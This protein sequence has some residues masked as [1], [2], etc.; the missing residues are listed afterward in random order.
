MRL[1][2]RL[3][4][5]FDRLG[6]LLLALSALLLLAMVLLLGVEIA[7]RALLRTSTQVADEY[8]GYLFTWMTLCSAVYAQR[9][10]R[11]IRVD[12]LRDRLAPRR[13]AL[14]DAIAA[15][16]AAALCAVL[17]HATWNTVQVSLQFGSVSLQPSQTPLALPQAIMPLGFL[18]LGAAF[19]HGAITDLLQALGVVALP[20][21]GH[22]VK[23]PLE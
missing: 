7:G 18:M 17:V 22:D 21:D 10:G 11:F 3:G 20:A 4:N 14:G 1:W 6:D 16:V 8:S 2:L 9:H 23:A 5:A 13:R 15:L 12:V 19:L